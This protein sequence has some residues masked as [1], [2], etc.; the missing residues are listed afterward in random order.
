MSRLMVKLSVTEDVKFDENE[1]WTVANQRR[2]AIA[3][4]PDLDT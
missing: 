2:G 1:V 3:D 4:F